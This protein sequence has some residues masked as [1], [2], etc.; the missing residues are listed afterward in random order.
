MIRL[1]LLAL[2]GCMIVGTL[3]AQAP[4]PQQ[5]PMI[6]LALSDQFE[7]LQNL[8]NHRGHVTVLLYGDRT[9]MPANRELG[10]K[11][12]TEFHPQAKGMTPVEARKVPPRPLANLPADKVSPNV[13]VL[14]VACIG[15][16]PKLVQTIIRNQIKKGSP[17]VPVWLDFED[18]MKTT[19]GLT[20]SVPNIV[21][22]DAW[23][24]M[25]FRAAGPLD[26]ATYQRL[27]QVIEYLRQEA[28]GLV[29]QER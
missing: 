1:F 17:D 12:H 7:Q 8:N 5:P 2:L 20:A 27:T 6:E 25:R 10:E 16:V 18:R 9:G 23:G 28:A 21:V 11:L 14:P 29:G 4:V 3:A 22:I 13:Y 19:F 15:Q 26:A 24:R